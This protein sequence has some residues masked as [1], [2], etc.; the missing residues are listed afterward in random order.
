MS[1]AHS[2]SGGVAEKQASDLFSNIQLKHYKYITH[3]CQCT[4]KNGP[5]MSYMFVTGIVIFCWVTVTKC[6]GLDN[7]YV[8]EMSTH[9]SGNWKAQG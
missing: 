2:V 9:S 8:T 6:L 4:V 5:Y 1:N 7:L 3:V